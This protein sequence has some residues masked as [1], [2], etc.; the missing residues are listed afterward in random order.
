MKRFRD[1]LNDRRGATALT[2]GL[3][4]V[5]IMGMTG[6]AVDYSLASN[7]RSKLQNAADAAALAGASVFTGANA[8]YAEARARAYLKAN[9]GAEA[10][11]VAI[12]FNFEDH[13]VTA[14]LSGQTSTMFMH[15]FD[16]DT[17][18]VGVASTALAPLKPTSAEIQVGGM[19]GYWA[20]KV[21][22]MVIRPG[23]STP[24]TVGTVIYETTDK[25]GANGRGTG[26][27]TMNPADGKITL[28]PFLRDYDSLTG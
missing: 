21:S 11:T 7:E 1:F 26:V 27:K 14:K 19:Y 16:Q 23:S 8:S 6:L 13:K 15:L 9:L 2:F 5:P 12:T 4:L 20:K 28:V 24:V 18:Q 25:S 22:I 17:V 10:D 3:L